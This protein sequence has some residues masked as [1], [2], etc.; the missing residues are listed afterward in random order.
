[1]KTTMKKNIDLMM[2]TRTAM[3]TQHKEQM[4]YVRVE[5]AGIAGSLMT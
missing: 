1:M 4:V 3:V 2:A 5:S